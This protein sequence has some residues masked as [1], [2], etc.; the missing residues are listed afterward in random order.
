MS[1][2][3]IAP[4]AAIV[5]RLY[6]ARIAKDWPAVASCFAADAMWQYSG[7]APIGR[8]YRGGSEIVG[9]LKALNNTA[10]GGGASRHILAND[11]VVVCCELNPVEGGENDYLHLFFVDD[12][13]IA[14]VK[15]FQCVQSKLNDRWW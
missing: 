6:D 7:P 11:E 1:E 4:K 5:R 12:I 14:R 3:S 9:L 8:T 15:S 2:Q 10:A 13:T